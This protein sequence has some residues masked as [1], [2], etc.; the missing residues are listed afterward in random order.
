LSTMTFSITTF[1]ITTFNIMTFSIN[2]F[3]ITTFNIMTYSIMPLM[4]IVRIKFK[5]IL[6]PL[7]DYRYIEIVMLNAAMLN[8][9][10]IN[11]VLLNVVMLN[12]IILNVVAPLKEK[13]G[14]PKPLYSQSIAL[15]C[16]DY[17]SLH[18]NHIS[19]PY[20]RGKDKEREK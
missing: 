1:S 4:L 2:T 11:V 10:L 14:C 17:M 6:S 13:S 9:V 18:A 8:V 15:R 19:I 16:L 20:G 5:C 12:V 3:S 7:A